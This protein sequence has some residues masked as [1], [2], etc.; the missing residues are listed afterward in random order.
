M[1]AQRLLCQMHPDPDPAQPHREME[2]NKNTSISEC[3]ISIFS[4][5]CFV[6]VGLVEQWVK[7]ANVRDMWS[8]QWRVH[9]NARERGIAID[10]GG[11]RQRVAT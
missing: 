7:I 4:F 2:A 11:A 8:K 6:L 3:L 10:A 9:G 5:V 1:P